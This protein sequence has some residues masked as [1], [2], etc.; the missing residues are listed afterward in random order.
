MSLSR[1]A[2]LKRGSKP[3]ARSRLRPVSDRKRQEIAERKEIVRDSCELAGHEF[4]CWGPIDKHEIV[5]RSQNSK[6]AVTPELV[7][8]LCRNHHELDVSRQVG[9]ALGIRIHGWQ[10]QNAT[11]EEQKQLLNEAAEKRRKARGG[12]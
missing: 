7:I 6:A 1:R 9:I 10:W 3:L 4:P 12:R 8:G 5:R 2:P 11:P